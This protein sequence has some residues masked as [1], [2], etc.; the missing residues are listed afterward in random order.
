L[1]AA[2]EVFMEFGFAR[3]YRGDRAKAGASKVTVFL[4]S[5]KK[6]TVY[7]T[8]ATSVANVILPISGD[9]LSLDVPI[10]ETLETFGAADG[11]VGD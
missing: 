2:T 8:S 5:S 1:E 4:L 7:R 3:R 11:D 10:E 9:P 6:G